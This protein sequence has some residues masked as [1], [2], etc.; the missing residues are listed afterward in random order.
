MWLRPNLVSSYIGF[1]DP[2]LSRDAT[3]I[4]YYVLAL[5][6]AAFIA[7][8]FLFIMG[9]FNPARN[10]TPV[11]I[12]ILWSTLMLVGQIYTLIKSYVEF[13][14]VFFNMIITVI[15]LIGFLV[16]YPWPFNRKSYR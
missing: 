8:G 14:H 9:S 3:S 11:R 1:N 10:V 2:F 13:T 16:F 7:G 15:F 12:A 4:L 5:A 6:G